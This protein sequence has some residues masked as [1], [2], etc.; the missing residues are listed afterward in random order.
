ML[1]PKEK[2]FKELI[3]NYLWKCSRKSMK[4]R[5]GEYLP[6]SIWVP[7]YSLNNIT[8]DI[9]AGITIAVVSIPQ[10]KKLFVN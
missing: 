6:C 10:G 4:E 8:A 3:K 5:L 9:I 2:H 7:Q 1:E